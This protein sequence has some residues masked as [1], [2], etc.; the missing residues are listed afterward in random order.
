MT[1]SRIDRS[2][3]SQIHWRQRIVV[4]TIISIICAI[5]LLTIVNRINQAREQLSQTIPR[6]TH[7]SM[8][9]SHHLNRLNSQLTEYR[10]AL[11]DGQQSPQL[12]Q[13]YRDRFEILWS[14]FQIYNS[15][16][17][18]DNPTEP[19]LEQN[20]RELARFLQQHEYRISQDDKLDLAG[21]DEFL[22]Q[23]SDQAI[24][25]HQV[26]MRYLNFSDV[27]R[28]QLSQQIDMLRRYL[29]IFSLLLLLAS[30]LLVRWLLK[31]KHEATL[32]Q[33]QQLLA[34]RQIETVVEELNSDKKVSAEK[35]S[36]FAAANHDLRQPLQAMTLLIDSLRFDVKTPR[37]NASLQALEK[38]SSNLNEMLNSLLDL[39]Q[40]D[41]G[42]MKANVSTVDLQHLIQDLEGEFTTAAQQAGMTLQLHVDAC[43]VDTDP[44]LFSRILRNL[45]SNTIRHSRATQMAISCTVA[46]N[47]VEVVVQDNGIG[48]PDAESARLIGTDYQIIN[49]MRDKSTGLGL[50]LAIVRRLC[51]LLGINIS[52]DNSSAGTSIF[53][54]LALAETN[55]AAPAL[56]A[57]QATPGNGELVAVIDDEPYIRTGMSALLRAWHFDVV[58]AADTDELVEQLKTDTRGPD[59]LIADY[60]LAGFKTGDVAIATLRKQ[61][62]QHL[63]AMLITGDS[64]A[65]DLRTTLPADVPLL[66]KPIEASELLKVLETLL[67]QRASDVRQE[68]PVLAQTG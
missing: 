47:R 58:V 46:G 61:F 4:M 8:Q 16:F 27:A 30:A 21:I 19:E 29:M 18:G 65:G 24:T 23:S 3:S 14:A 22:E 36:L 25:L 63:P 54:Q 67:P 5:A 44:V 9:V 26:A 41:A 17:R 64:G 2:D 57:R 6:A 34:E 48:I 7:F 50:G 62:G 38:C 56:P 28:G 59:V 51:E 60:H 31:A 13:A 33:A 45:F 42:R 43:A 11:A 32:H 20:S 40:L 37:A 66:N 49:P 53:L 39:S 1:T 55:S 12:Q 10:T 68:S 35:D 15:L 52:V